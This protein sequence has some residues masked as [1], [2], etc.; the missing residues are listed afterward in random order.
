[1][2][3]EPLVSPPSGRAGS[4]FPKVDPSKTVHF[5]SHAFLQWFMTFFDSFNC[6]L[7]KR[8]RNLTIPLKRFQIRFRRLLK[9]YKIDSKTFRNVFQSFEKRS[10]GPQRASRGFPKR[11]RVF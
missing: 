1:M 7:Q 5:D 10:R 8:F 3:P 11:C 4:T 9:P 6:Y 2:P